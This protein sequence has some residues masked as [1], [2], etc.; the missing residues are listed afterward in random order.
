MQPVKRRSWSTAVGVVLVCSV[1]GCTIEFSNDVTSF[2]LAVGVIAFVGA[3]LLYLIWRREGHPGEVRRIFAFLAGLPLS[4]LTFLLVEPD[5]DASNRRAWLEE[6][7]DDPESV[8]ADFQ[9]ELARVRRMRRVVPQEPA[10]LEA[11]LEVDRAP[12]EESEGQ[13]RNTLHD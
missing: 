1:S 9:R 4:F 13:S 3:N 8:E 7:K 10:A 6:M 12:R 5:R 11:T 2:S